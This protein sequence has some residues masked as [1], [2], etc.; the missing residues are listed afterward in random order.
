MSRKNKVKKKKTVGDHI[1]TIVLIVAICIF[2][3]AAFNLYHIYTEY[4]KG[5]D[6]YNSISEMAV[7]ERDPDQV[8]EIDQPDE[9]PVAPVSIDFDSLRSINEDV[10]GWIYME[11]LP[12]IS[13]PVVQGDDNEYYLHHTFEKK[14]NFSGAIFMDI[15]CRPDFSSDNSI[16][17]GHNLKTGEMFGELKKLYDTDYNSEADYRKHPIVWVV[18]P[19]TA[20]EY[21]IFAAREIS[22]EKDTDMYM[23]DFA[24]KEEYQAWMQ[25]QKELSM[26]ETDTDISSFEPMLTLSTCTSDTE[27]GRFVVQAVRIQKSVQ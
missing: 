25:K 14:E 9:Q 1:L 7:T 17:F 2:C 3:Y 15:T 27:D 13:Y 20:M 5:T 21:Q 24:Q 8:E 18:T 26:Y 4:K 16:L 22:V 23:V 6:E 12:E 11:A 19:D 10:I